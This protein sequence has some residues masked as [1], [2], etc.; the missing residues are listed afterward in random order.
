MKRVLW[1][2]G[3]SC[4]VVNVGYA[5]DAALNQ[6]APLMAVTQERAATAI[7]EV[8]SYFKGQ[9][10]LQMANSK[11]ETV[12]ASLQ[13]GEHL[14]ALAKQAF[15]EQAYANALRHSNNAIKQF[16][17]TTQIFSPHKSAVLNKHADEG[18]TNINDRAPLKVITKERA[19]A[20]LKEMDSYFEGPLAEKIHGVHDDAVQDSLKESEALRKQAKQA[21]KEQSYASSIR[22]SNNAIKTFLDTSQKTI[23]HQPLI[24]QQQLAYQSQL[25]KV[26][27]F[28]VA[29]EQAA[30]D[31]GDD[32]Q[33]TFTD[34][35]Q[36][37][38]LAEE[39]AASKKYLEGTAV[40]DAVTIAI[41]ADIRNLLKGEQFKAPK[42]E[43]PKGIYKY[44]L[45]RNDTY[46]ALVD[47]VCNSENGKKFS[48]ENFFKQHER[49]GDELH[50]EGLSLAE[51]EE[52][53]AATA[54]LAESTSSYKY[55]VRRAGIL[56][57]D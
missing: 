34:L 19:E 12:L 6:R 26:N 44:E 1:V 31:V 24:V 35:S 2:L 43:S 40:L 32:H 51:R 30:K 25:K 42:D 23:P 14:R 10:A 36:Q 37:V 5:D 16:F 47:L 22:Y 20:A 3:L 17:D 29:L 54:K 55:A 46:R 39:L 56:I 45:F 21:F 7:E 52:F 13:E 49:E 18:V 27:T 53:E 50:E 28:M 15:D 38:V 8:D 57:P 48:Q 9:Q 4:L 41:K 11:D 33:A